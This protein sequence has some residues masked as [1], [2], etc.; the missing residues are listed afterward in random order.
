MLFKVVFMTSGYIPLFYFEKRNLFMSNINIKKVIKLVEPVLEN[1]GYELVDLECQNE[2]TG[3]V[4]RL[5]IDKKGGV[6][7]DDCAGINR[8]LGNILDV[9]DV[10]TFKYRLEVSSP[11]LSR[12]LRKQKHFE[13]VIGEQVKVQTFELV[14]GAKNFK[15]KL[16]SVN[17]GTITLDNGVKQYTVDLE[18]IKKA[19]LI[20]KFNI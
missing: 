3:W 18:N 13:K 10:I 5:F 19:S 2:H 14:D 7:I 4:L 20:Y 1:E 11:G 8:E 6:N 17:N 15:A 16:V 9:E 12:P